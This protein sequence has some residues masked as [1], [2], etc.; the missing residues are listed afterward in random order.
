MSDVGQLKQIVADTRGKGLRREAK[1]QLAPLLEV[2]VQQESHAEAVC[3]ELSQLNWTDG[4]DLLARAWPSIPGAARNVYI[5]TLWDRKDEAKTVSSAR[6][7]L[8]A[9]ILQ[10][11]ESSAA[12]LLDLVFNVMRKKPDSLRAAFSRTWLRAADANSKPPFDALRW[13]VMG[14]T[15]RFDL[16]EVLVAAAREAAAPGSGKRPNA[17]D[18]R[19]MLIEWLERLAGSTADGDSAR[20][21]AILRRLTDRPPAPAPPATPERAPHHGSNSAPESKAMPPVEPAAAAPKATDAATNAPA[22]EQPT[23]KALQPRSEGRAAE[24]TDDQSL[25]G[26][27]R[28]LAD[29][30]ATLGALIDREEAATQK[31]LSQATA[32]LKDS[33]VERQRIQ[34]TLSA[35][36]TDLGKLRATVTSLNESV[37]LTSEALQAAQNRVAAIESELGTLRSRLASTEGQ[38]E[39]LQK[40]LEHE[41]EQVIRERDLARREA[42]RVMGEQIAATLA[43]ELATLSE[44]EKTPPSGDGEAFLRR[45]VSEMIARLETQGVPLRR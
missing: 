2:L 38:N 45:V 9:A 6:L 41:R 25:R 36:T 34:E 22:T 39:T 26:T 27:A 19:P 1:E 8:A 18:P 31:Q 7:A 35:T 13:E 10:T 44:I 17:P 40:Q 5:R 4:V 12:A 16:V 20:L 3:D 11:D 37:A 43:E 42:R 23:V 15:W 29:L 30:S 21:R 28:R 14:P 24:R 33:E 32:K